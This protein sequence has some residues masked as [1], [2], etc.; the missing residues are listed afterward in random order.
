MTT[1]TSGATSSKGLE[2]PRQGVIKRVGDGT[3]MNI[4]S[5]PWLPKLWCSRPA[6]PRGVTIISKV[7][8][9]IDP[10]TGSWDTELVQQTFWPQDA[11]LIFQCQSLRIL[12][13]NGPGTLR[14]MCAKAREIQ[15]RLL[16]CEGA[17]E[18]IANVT[19]LE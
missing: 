16:L 19:K 7:S 18:F 8:E 15:E 10:F 9:L 17:Q 6:T 13:M 5:D 3:T 2:L 4:W 1:L 11:I 14:Q 12:R